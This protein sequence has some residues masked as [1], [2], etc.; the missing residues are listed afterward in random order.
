MVILQVVFRVLLQA[1]LLRM[2]YAK[3]PFEKLIKPA[4]DLAENGFIINEKGSK[5]FK[6]FTGRFQKY[7]IP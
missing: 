7:T 5:C 3:L 1:Y 4:I 2:Q 6:W